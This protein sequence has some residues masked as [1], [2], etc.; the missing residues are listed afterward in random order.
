MAQNML[1]NI[2]GEGSFWYHF[3]GVKRPLILWGF[4]LWNYPIFLLFYFS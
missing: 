4:S 3:F 1:L 2:L